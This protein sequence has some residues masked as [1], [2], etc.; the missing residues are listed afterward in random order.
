MFEIN[1]GVSKNT[2]AKI[3]NF[4]LFRKSRPHSR[5]MMECLERQIILMVTRF[6][7]QMKG[8]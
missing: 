6:S 7:V 1:L 2:V 3:Q 5:G 4:N 8:F